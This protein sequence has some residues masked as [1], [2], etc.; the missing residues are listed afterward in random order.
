[1]KATNTQQDMNNQED[2]LSN[3]ERVVTYSLVKA[4]EYDEFQ[5]KHK[6]PIK[7]IK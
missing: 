3:D 6:I 1:M 5:R 4:Y 7:V 2:S